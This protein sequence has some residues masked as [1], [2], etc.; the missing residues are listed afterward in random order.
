VHDEKFRN[1]IGLRAN[2]SFPEASEFFS[3]R[4]LP[5]LKKNKR[6]T[7]ALARS[8]HSV[9]VVTNS[10]LY[11]GQATAAAFDAET[12]DRTIE[13]ITRGLYFH[14][15]GLPI[16]PDI[17]I[18]A[19][20]IRDGSEWPQRLADAF[21][22]MHFCNVGGENVFEYAHGRVA[23]MPDVSMWFYRFYVGHVAFAITGLEQ[24]SVQ[25]FGAT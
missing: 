25:K 11:L 2:S 16:A 8:M 5:G 6:E 24:V 13:R 22:Q 23:G 14:H 12:H 15:Y 20:F 19:T 21:Q 3:K 7:R 1:L 9:S 10:G 4:T 17:S 18:E